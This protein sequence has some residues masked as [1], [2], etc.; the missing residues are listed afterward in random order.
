M[1]NRK[2]RSEK[3]WDVN[4]KIALDLFKL[5]ENYKHDIYQL[6]EYA[7]IIRNPIVFD[8][9]VKETLFLLNYNVPNPNN[10]KETYDHLMGMSNIVL[11]IIKNDLYKKWK[12]VDDFKDTLRALQVTI[13]CPT[14]INNSNIFRKW[15][16]SYESV[17]YS[18]NWADKLKSNGIDYLIDN[19]GKKVSVEKVWSEWFFNNKNFLI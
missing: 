16:F 19:N 12:S 17:E 8:N 13:T 11:Y 4:Y 2:L 7:K 6:E 3:K 10:E 9:Q 14:S 1:S 15:V 18:I 5:S